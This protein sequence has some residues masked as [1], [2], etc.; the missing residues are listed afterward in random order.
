M[1]KQLIIILT[2]LVF[3]YLLFSFVKN[4]FNTSNWLIVDRLGLVLSLGITYPLY[5]LMELNK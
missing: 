1:K 4:D 3:T 2:I 5:K